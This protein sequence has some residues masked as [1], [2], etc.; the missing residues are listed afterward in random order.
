MD[1]GT[2]LLNNQ[3]FCALGALQGVRMSFCRLNAKQ[4]AVGTESAPDQ[5]TEGSQYNN[6]VMHHDADRVIV[7]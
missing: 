1:E 6:A 2:K 3:D 4:F 5:I 7:L